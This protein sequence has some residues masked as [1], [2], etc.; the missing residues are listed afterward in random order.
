MVNVQRDWTEMSTIGVTMT[1]V[2]MRHFS[3]ITHVWKPIQEMYYNFD[4]WAMF[5]RKGSDVSTQANQYNFGCWNTWEFSY[6]QFSYSLYVHSNNQIGTSLGNGTNV[7]VFIHGSLAMHTLTNCHVHHTISTKFRCAPPTCS[8]VLNYMILFMCQFF[9]WKVTGYGLVNKWWTT[10]DIFLMSVFI[11]QLL[12]RHWYVALWIWHINLSRPACINDQL[13]TLFICQFTYMKSTPFAVMW[14]HVT[15]WHGFIRV[16][17]TEF[18]CKGSN[19]SHFL[20]QWQG[21][22]SVIFIKFK[23][24]GTDVSNLCVTMTGMLISFDLGSGQ[25]SQCNVSY[26]KYDIHGI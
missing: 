16:T 18:K 8:S 15:Q 25:L 4:Y 24:K 26:W 2:H 19:V 1:G 3:E 14:S 5:M 23:Y 21:F 20:S 10:H 9:I 6:I 12:T 13:K 11:Q 17:F 7:T 22:I